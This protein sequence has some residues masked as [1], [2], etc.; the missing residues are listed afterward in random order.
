MLIYQMVKTMELWGIVQQ[1]MLDFTDKKTLSG[2][3]HA[4]MILWEDSA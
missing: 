2:G 1:A 4:Q 3:C